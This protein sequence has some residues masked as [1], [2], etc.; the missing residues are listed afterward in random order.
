MRKFIELHREKMLGVL[1]GFDR[2]RFRGTVRR[3]AYPDGLGKLMGF[4]KVRLTDFDDF[5]QQTTGRFRAGV[6]RMAE[7]AGL[8]VQHLPSPSVDKERLVQDLLAKRGPAGPGVVAVLSAVEMCRSFELHR[9]REQKRV[10]VRSAARKCLHYYVYLQDRQFGLSHVRLQTWFPFSVHVLLNGRE[11]LARQMDRARLA[12]ERADN[13]FPWIADFGRAQRLADQ[14]LRMRWP[15]ALNRLLRQ[16]QPEFFRLFPEATYDPYWTVEQSEWATD[17]AFRSA[18]DLA[19]LYSPCVRYALTHF[20][21]PDVLR[22]L[23]QHTTAQ[24][25]VHGAFRGEVQS[26]LK[27]RREGVRIKHRVGANSLKMYDKPNVLR[28]ETTLNQAGDLK[29][30]RP[31]ADAPR[32]KLV[33]QPLRKGVADLHRRAQL[34]Q[35][36]NG[37][38]LDAL[39]AADASTPLKVLLAPLSRPVV[40]AGAGEAE[41]G[42]RWRALQPLG[43]DAELLAAASRGEWLMKGFRNRELREVLWGADPEDAGERRRRSARMGRLL[44][45]L[46][47]HGLIYRIPQTQRYQVTA[48]G[49]KV[50][51]AL[52]AAREATL[53]KL[54]A[55]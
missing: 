5:V 18:E 8:P 22:F 20:Q 54:L 17:V 38:Y 26:D 45:L 4:L 10:E 15:R 29:V 30:L 51:P 53:D 21:S 31:K 34:C 9:N 7:A 48:L 32:G 14:Q 42:R 19:E 50:L 25:R 27:G 35:A 16:A 6:E 44:R 28:V 36:A 2:L 55:A 49:R 12:Y 23:G 1:S 3:W 41:R 33:Y 40:E 43:Q 52:S 37:R 39:A 46:R 47:A 11:W 13:C 24:G